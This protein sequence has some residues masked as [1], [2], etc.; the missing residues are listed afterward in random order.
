VVLA[1]K[2]ICYYP[3]GM[4][5]PGRKYTAPSSSYRYG[6]VGKEM[7][8]E[9]KG[10]GNQYDFGARI[11]DPRLGRFLSVDPKAAKYPFF[12]PYNYAYNNPI[13]FIDGDGEDGMLSGS[14]TKEDPYIIKA[15]Y[16]YVKGSIS[17][18]QAKGLNAATALYNNKNKEGNNQAFEIKKED[19]SVV[20]V[21]FDLTVVE[22]PEGTDVSTDKAM[23]SIRMKDEY[24]FNDTKDSKRSFANIVRN[25]NIEGFDKSTYDAQ[26]TNEDL[27][28][29]FFNQIGYYDNTSSAF[30]EQAKAFMDENGFGG[31][32][33][34]DIDVLTSIMVH[35]IFHNL[36][37]EH[38]D[39]V[40]E[41]KKVGVTWGSNSNTM[42]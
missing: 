27:G 32:K 31:Q 42:G 14:G 1:L 13:H 7:D 2:E 22:L 25:E 24:T 35:E 28:V 33:F 15:T 39:N 36:G 23:N 4:L 5:M 8:N 26:T 9:V 18:N 12:T 3:F 10:N 20:H 34:K 11:Y 19:G 30:I 41:M 40:S 38:E 16:L 6:F 29:A 17:E 37:G 21:K